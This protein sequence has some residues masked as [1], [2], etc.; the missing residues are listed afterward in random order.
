M[1]SNLP[2]VRSYQRL[3]APQCDTP[4]KEIEEGKIRTHRF[5]CLS[6]QML[7]SRIVRAYVGYLLEGLL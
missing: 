2:G 7:M 4:H 3:T 6:S 1:G 5:E